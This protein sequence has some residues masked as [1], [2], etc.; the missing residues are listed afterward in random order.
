MEEND[1]K[2]LIPERI[3]MTPI[4]F[5]RFEKMLDAEPKDMPKL[6]ALMNR[7][8]IWTDEPCS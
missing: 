6:R 4:Q 5:E 8:V 1:L 2:N 3:S 7:P